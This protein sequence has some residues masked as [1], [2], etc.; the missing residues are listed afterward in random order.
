MLKTEYFT[1]MIVKLGRCLDGIDDKVLRNICRSTYLNL[2][3][4]D[5]E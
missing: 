5:F 1:D 4:L 2:R 3:K